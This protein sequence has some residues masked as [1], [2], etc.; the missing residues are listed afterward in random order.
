MLWLVVF[1]V[2]MILVPVLYFYRRPSPIS[3]AFVLLWLCVAILGIYLFGGFHTAVI[4][5]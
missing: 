5:R 1:V 4:V 2:L 3:E